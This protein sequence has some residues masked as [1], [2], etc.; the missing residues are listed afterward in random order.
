MT[1]I[2]NWLFRAKE[3]S[4]ESQLAD[5]QPLSDP[6]LSVS[7]PFIDDTRLGQYYK[8]MPNFKKYN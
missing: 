7:K 6:V 2:L 1:G 8:Q 3:D 5:E 4:I